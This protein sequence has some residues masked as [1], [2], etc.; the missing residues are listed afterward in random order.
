M[1]EW[2]NELQHFEALSFAH[3][4]YRLV[5]NV[6]HNLTDLHGLLQEVL[7]FNELVEGH[8]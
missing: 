3:R 4:A 7:F 8:V 6:C 2:H 1:L 5:D